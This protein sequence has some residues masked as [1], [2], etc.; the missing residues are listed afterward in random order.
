MMQKGLNKHP[1]AYR[2]FLF[3]SLL[4]PLA[5]FGVV[6]FL[7][8]NVVLETAEQ[9]VADTT[10][11]FETHALNV[12]EICDLI[13]NLVDQKTRDMS[14]DEIASSQSVH[15]YL[16]N[17]D[18]R[19]PH[20]AGIGLV[21]PD[22]TLRNSSITFP[23]P[24]A[25]LSDRDYF[26]GLREKGYTSFVGLT[27]PNRLNAQEN[28]SFA[29]RR[30]SGGPDFDGLIVV[31]VSPD[32][33]VEFWRKTAPYPNRMAGLLRSDL[34]ILAR[35]PVDATTNLS[36]TSATAIAIRQSDR[37][38]Y[39]TVSVLDGIE[40]LMAFQ[41]IGSY[42]VYMTHGIAVS[43]ALAVWYRHLAI[44]GGFFALA[45]VAS[46]WF[47]YRLLAE[48]RHRYLAETRLHQ[49][50]KMEAL[51]QLTGQFAHDFGNILT[52]ILLNLEALRGGSRDP[53]ELDEAV[54]HAVSAAQQGEKV[55]QSMLAFARRQPLENEVV[56]IGATLTGIEVMLQQALGSKSQLELAISPGTWPVKSDRVQLEL[57]V[58]NL[59]V[60]ARDAMPDGGT[61]RVS[62]SNEHIEGEPNGLA[63]E[64]VVLSVADTGAGI[65]QEI[66][67]RVFDPFFTTKE[68]GKGTGLG[69]SQVYSFAAA[70]G[71]TATV[72]SRLGQGT[73]VKIYLPRAPADAAVLSRKPVEVADH[74]AALNKRKPTILVVEDEEVIRRVVTRVLFE[75][76]Y[77]VLEAGTGDEGLTILTN[78]PEIDLILTD[79]RMPG[80]WDGISMAA[81]ARR[82]RPELKIVFAT[83]YP[84]A[85]VNSETATVLKK[86]YRAYQILGAVAKELPAEA[87]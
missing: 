40:R 14:W 26:I 85:L 42:D 21:D 71:G 56:E 28:F 74:R 80:R 19:Y 30:S 51:G 82:M 1:S 72:E 83:A 27:V 9:Q 22:G 69:L 50:E 58:L 11:V 7:D 43:T 33:F 62:A 13:E 34:A 47:S 16:K 84:D 46:F 59:A 64:F 20:V 67:S 65:P 48:S 57:A 79:V 38:S 63:G 86:P 18:E 4:I 37:G 81:Q 76:G 35:D 78:H 41:R 5:L 29:H 77:T 60:N 49:S 39:R 87:V 70:C 25:N 32:Y 54:N 45:A 61:L 52:G 10:D 53:T 15:E 6:V 2:A 36:P 3:A 12:F 8:Y 23:T 31:R 75:S 66:I 17:L 24:P 68:E 73:T 44:Y 55:V